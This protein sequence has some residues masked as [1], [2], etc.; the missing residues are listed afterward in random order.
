MKSLNLILTAI[1]SFSSFNAVAKIYA[2]PKHIV[3]IVTSID[4]IHEKMVS[5]SSVSTRHLRIEKIDVFKAI[6][7][8]D[9]GYCLYGCRV[10]LANPDSNVKTALDDNSFF[11]VEDIVMGK[12]KF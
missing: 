7:R 5:L 1:L 10:Y 6:E 9:I 3:P 12:C 2:H 4:P 11:E 8:A